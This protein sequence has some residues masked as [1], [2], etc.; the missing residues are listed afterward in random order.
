LFALQAATLL[1]PIAIPAL[2]L[3]IAIRRDIFP[4]LDRPIDGGV[5]W[6]K[7]PVMG[8][9]K[10]Y[11]ALLIY[12]IGSTVVTSVLFYFANHGAV[13][14]HW[15][16]KHNPIVLGIVYALSYELGEYINSFIKRRLGI[17]PG[18]VS[19]R[20]VILQRFFDLADGVI[21]STTVLVLVYGYSPHIWIVL[22]FGI[23]LH[24]C[25]EKIKL[26]Q[27]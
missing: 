10:T 7:R 13:W 17:K 21:M 3:I 2:V 25:A 26:K 9:N 11:R 20:C 12:L 5:T 24:Y 27:Q 1:L 23:L 8:R 18:A 14:T 16:F 4:S 19:K 6:H 22:A 15:L